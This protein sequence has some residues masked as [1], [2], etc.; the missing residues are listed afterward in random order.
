MHASGLGVELMM[1]LSIVVGSTPHDNFLNV[2]MCQECPQCSVCSVI[3]QW[4][5]NIALFQE[6]CTTI[7]LCDKDDI[8]SC[9]DLLTQPRS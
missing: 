5:D 9:S 6:L 4:E 3:W 8:V 7:A 2:C 1:H